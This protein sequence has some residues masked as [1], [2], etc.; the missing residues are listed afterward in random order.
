MELVFKKCKITPWEGRYARIPG[1]RTIFTVKKIDGRLG[2]VIYWETVD[3]TGICRALP[4]NAVKL[5]TDAILQ[6]KRSLG[7]GSGGSF[8]INEF[9]Q[10]IVPASDG[11]GR[12]V[13]AGE[14]QGKLLFENPFVDNGKIDLSDT[15]GLSCG[16][17]WPLPYVGMPYR[18]SKK[19]KLYFVKETE[20]GNY[21]EN[22]AKQDSTLIASLKKVRGY[23]GMRFIVNPYG[24][25]LTKKPPEWTSVYIGKINRSCWFNKEEC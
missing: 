9:G 25:V 5:L 13:F 10:V 17:A 22:P 15:S 4:S 18:L 14:I 24:I 23:S 19:S 3:G 11:S 7:G 21:F 8:A 2:P 12:R 6:A 1:E 20:D 16:D